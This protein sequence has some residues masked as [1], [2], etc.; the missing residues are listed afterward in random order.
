MSSSWARGRIAKIIND[1]SKFVADMISEA[2]WLYAHS[3]TPAEREALIAAVGDLM[4]VLAAQQIPASEV[5]ALRTRR[6]KNVSAPWVL[7]EC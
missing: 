1:L 2:A 6:L 5:I 3:A 7:R 4:D